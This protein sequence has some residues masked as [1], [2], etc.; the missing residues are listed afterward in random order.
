M[1]LPCFLR[2]ARSV[3]CNVVSALSTEY[4]QVDNHGGVDDDE[5]YC[6]P[7]APRR[8]IMFLRCVETYSSSMSVRRIPD[9]SSVLLC[10]RRRVGYR[11]QG[12]MRRLSS[13][14]EIG[15]QPWFW[16]RCVPK[17]VYGGAC[18]GAW[19]V[20]VWHSRCLKHEASERRS[21]VGQC[22]ITYCAQGSDLRRGLLCHL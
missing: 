17:K 1:S 18:S 4:E 21:R 14:L 9:L 5:G 6:M 19:W 11:S 7:L 13:R 12:R 8:A 22:I 3:I 16:N 20:V 2:Y 10:L 15:G